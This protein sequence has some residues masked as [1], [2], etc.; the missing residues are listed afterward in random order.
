MKGFS[1][2]AERVQ[3]ERGRVRERGGERERKSERERVCEREAQRER[4]RDT[5]CP[6]PQSRVRSSPRSIERSRGIET[7]TGIS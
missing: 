1:G 3:E 2:T 5:A 4:E 6:S 7:V